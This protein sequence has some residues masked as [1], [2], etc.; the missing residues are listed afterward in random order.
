MRKFKAMS[1]SEMSFIA[2]TVFCMSFM[3]FGLFGDGLSAI[4]SSTRLTS[5]FA[6]PSRILQPEEEEFQLS[7]KTFAFKGKEYRSPIEK[8]IINGLRT[9]TFSET[10]GARGN[11]K[12]LTNVMTEYT[13]QIEEFIQDIPEEYDTT[14]FTEAFEAYKKTVQKYVD[15]NNKQVSGTDDP[16]VKVLFG[17]D[18]SLTLDEDGDAATKLNEE[19]INLTSRMPDSDTK[20][21]LSAYTDDLQNLGKSID[22]TLDTRALD[23]LGL[24]KSSKYHEVNDLLKSAFDFDPGSSGIDVTS[25][26]GNIGIDATD[27]RK[28]E[29]YCI[30]EKDEDSA[31]LKFLAY[32]ESVGKRDIVDDCTNNHVMRKACWDFWKLPYKNLNGEEFNPYNYDDGQ[33]LLK[34]GVSL[35]FELDTRHD[36]KKAPRYIFIDVD[37]P[38]KGDNVIGKDVFVSMIFG[39]TV[40]PYGHPDY[41]W[42]VPIRYTS[43]DF[44]KDQTCI[45]GNTDKNNTGW[46]CA[47]QAYAS[48][49]QVD[50]EDLREKV[51]EFILNNPDQ[52]DELIKGIKVYRNGNYNE[53]AKN[54]YNTQVLCETMNSN[55]EDNKCTFENI[56]PDQNLN[57]D[58]HISSTDN[59]FAQ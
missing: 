58:V 33:I 45:P 12:E 36:S 7:N 18:M 6:G 31:V 10:T 57:S 15:N 55:I 42:T 20:R 32:L 39:S 43:D 37:G 5:Q 41:E 26:V 47:Y 11:V 22:F 19:L 30:R 46:P 17:I 48:K 16:V 29:G 2:I 40:V 54:T 44:S 21:L 59:V 3:A 25:D 23:L 14:D 34:N 1:V 52:A 53:I 50:K 28:C 4:F 9:R 35:T 56:N 27:A 49:N 51:T 8:V 13:T 38:F 24:N